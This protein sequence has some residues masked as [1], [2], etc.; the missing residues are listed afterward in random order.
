MLK[1][2]KENEYPNMKRKLEDRDLAKLDA[3]K[4]LSVDRTLNRESASS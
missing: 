4:D 1:N 2:L 3:K